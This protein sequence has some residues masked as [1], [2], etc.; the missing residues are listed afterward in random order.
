MRHLLTS[1]ARSKGVCRD[2]VLVSVSGAPPTP[3]RAGPEFSGSTARSAATFLLPCHPHRERRGRIRD[4]RAVRQGRRATP[5]S[6]LIGCPR[7]ESHSPERHLMG[8]PHSSLTSPLAL[9]S[10]GLQRNLRR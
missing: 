2:A 9:L 6:R 7:R 8:E 4:R 5:S 1:S 10:K 3:R